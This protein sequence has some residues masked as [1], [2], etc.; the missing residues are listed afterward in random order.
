MN[1]TNIQ[2]KGSPGANPTVLYFGMSEG[3]IRTDWSGPFAY[4][5]WIWFTNRE[6]GL[7]MEI[8]LVM[9]RMILIP[10]QLL[11]EDVCRQ[12]EYE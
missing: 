4:L 1:R 12:M 9:K 7:S 3:T 5:H 2:V 11:V 8:L 6:T 10:H